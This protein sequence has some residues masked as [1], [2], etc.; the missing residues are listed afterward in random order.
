MRELFKI[1]PKGFYGVDKIGRP[2]YIDLVGKSNPNE[3]F[4]EFDEEFLY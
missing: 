4:K 3:V 2:I 1:S